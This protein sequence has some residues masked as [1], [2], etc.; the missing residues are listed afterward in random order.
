MSNPEFKVEIKVS[1]VF[2]PYAVAEMEVENE[3]KE[4]VKQ[5]VPGVKHAFLARFEVFEIK[6]LL[7]IPYKKSR[8]DDYEYFY[9]V[10]YPRCRYDADVAYQEIDAYLSENYIRMIEDLKER[11]AESMISRKIVKLDGKGE[12]GDLVGNYFSG[13]IAFSVGNEDVITLYQKKLEKEKA[14]SK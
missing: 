9:D 3:E 13:K 7:G 5:C 1:H 12:V 4:M 11:I 6:S 14:Q 10:V 2:E 8:Y